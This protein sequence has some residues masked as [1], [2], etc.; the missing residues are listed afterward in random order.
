MSNFNGYIVDFCVGFNHRFL[1]RSQVGQNYVKSRLFL[2]SDMTEVTKYHIFTPFYTKQRKFDSPL[3]H[4]L[5]SSRK[6]EQQ[7]NETS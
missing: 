1:D 6:C 2:R 7:T 4:T 5:T 3:Q